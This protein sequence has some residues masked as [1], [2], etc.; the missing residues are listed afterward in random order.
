MSVSANGN[1]VFGRS[2]TLTDSVN[3]YGYKVVNPGA[4]QT[5]SALPLF[6]DEAG[7]VSL[8]VP[9]GC[10]ADGN[11]AVGMA[12]RGTEKAVLWSTKDD[13]SFVL[14]LTHYA[15]ANSL[16]DGFSRLSR[17]YSVGE[18]LDGFGNLSAVITGVGSWSPDGGVTPYVTRAFVMTVMVP[19]P[20]T[21]SLLA[22]GLFGLLALRRRK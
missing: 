12:Y 1:V 15:S 4:S 22:L 2:H 9:Y 18:S 7:S 10:T 6:G 20:G 19:E 14:D 21:I 17:A 5:I 11:F 16:L 3:Y 8:Q 13:R